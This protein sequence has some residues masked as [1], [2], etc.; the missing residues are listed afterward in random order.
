MQ[1]IEQ[2]HECFK[3]DGELSENDN[4]TIADVE[5]YKRNGIEL[6]TQYEF[7]RFMRH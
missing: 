2:I 5:H 3:I 7:N 4:I 6:Q 1:N